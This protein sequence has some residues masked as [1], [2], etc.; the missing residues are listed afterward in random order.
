MPPEYINRYQITSKFDVFSLGVIIIQVMTGRE[1]YLKCG[2]MPP[3]DF[4]ELVR[5]YPTSRT[6]YL[7]FTQHIILC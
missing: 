7:F 3:Q 2:N 5:K 6:P 4:I 1:G